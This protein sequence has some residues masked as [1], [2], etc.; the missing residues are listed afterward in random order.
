MAR[1]ISVG[2]QDFAKIR[3]NKYF[4]IDKTNFIEEWW[5]GGDS[6][7]LIT[8][9][10]RFGKTLNLSM[11]ECFFSNEYANRGDLFEG[12]SIWQ[13]EKFRQ[14]QGT[15]PVIFLSFAGVKFSDFET[16]RLMINRLIATL[17]NKYAGMIQS[18]IFTDTDRSDFSKIQRIMDDDIAVS[19]LNRLCEW[20]TRYY[21][22]KCI[23]IL[24]EYDTPLQEAYIHGFWDELV[25]YTRAFFN[26]TFKSNTYLERGLMTG[27]TRVS[28]ESIFSDLNNLNVVTTTSRQYMT[29]F[30]FTEEEVFAAMEEQ[31]IDSEQR[32]NVKFWYDG[33]T[34]GT[35]TD[36]YNP[37]SI[38]SYLDKKLFDS[39][40]AN[41]SGNGLI[42][43]VLREGDKGIKQDFEKL[44]NGSSVE[45]V[46]DEQIIFDQLSRNR[47]SIWS[48]LLAS[49]YL[50]VEKIIQ[51]V[52]EDDAVYVLSLTNFE[53]KKM[54]SRMIAGWFEADSSFGEFVAAM[55][56]GDDEAM[57]YYMNKIALQTFSY[58]DA[59]KEPSDLL[60]PEKFY[61]GFVLGLMVDKA[62]AYIIKSNRE[63]GFG[64]YD[65]LME[66]KNLSD[67]AVIMEFKVFNPNREESLSDTV[68]NAL[69]Q[70]EEKRYD[71]DLLAKGIPAEN[72]LK[73]GFAFEGKKCLIKKA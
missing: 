8:R 31:E 21:G 6:V 10:R 40:W 30:G 56:Q 29:S 49:G 39:Y 43:K 64:R 54:F 33:F 52:P 53:V 60:E 23:V 5:D 25:N 45:A 38:I 34:F 59:G 65:V 24:D 61:H 19:A 48:L 47:N 58:F 51:E 72:I 68:E 26:N 62:S 14:L 27:I 1:T 55:L 20:L 22:K 57:N 71:A 50:K 46:I 13:D 7:T 37:W 69:M 11:V 32:E 16:T 12:L 70:I 36:I 44:L 3:E 35:Q 66:P 18:N 4:Y 17:C 73:Y 2:A 9:P 15:F 41:T 42:S 28:K 67:R 63:S